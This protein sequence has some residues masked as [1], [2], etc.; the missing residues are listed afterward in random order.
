MAPQKT[1]INAFID[2][3]ASC[4]KLQFG[5]SK[6]K[7]LHVVKTKSKYKCQNLK[8]GEWKVKNVKNTVTND[9]SPEDI[10]TGDSDISETNE[11]NT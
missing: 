8:I 4:K 7:K 5:V 6:C 9:S 3:K 10:F 11:E 1:A 2:T